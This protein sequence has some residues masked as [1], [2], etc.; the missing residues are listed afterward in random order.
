VTPAGAGAAA[1]R[2]GPAAAPAPTARECFHAD[3][4][5]YFRYARLDGF[6]EKLRLAMHT[7]ALLAIGVYRFGQW[8]RAEAPPAVRM[9]LKPVHTLAHEGVRLALGICLSPEARIGPGLY[10]GHSG[11]IWI[12]PGAVLGR[13]CNLSQG[14]T[15]GVGG[16]VRRGA[17]VLGDRVWVGPKATVTGPVRVGAGAVVG[18]NSLVVTNVPERGVAVGVPARVVAT[19]GSDALVG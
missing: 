1:G 15:L 12:A 10:I 6:W 8:L 11:G 3:L 13:D 2:I 17:P 16:T 14:V 4:G 5:R 9:A 7:E 18:A 19:S